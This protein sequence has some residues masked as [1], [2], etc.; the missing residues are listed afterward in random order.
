[1]YVHVCNS[2][3]RGF[4]TVQLDVVNFTPVAPQRRSVQGGA[5][6]LDAVFQFRL[7]V[8]NQPR[9]CECRRHLETAERESVHSHVHWLRS[10]TKQEQQKFVLAFWDFPSAWT[11][12]AVCREHSG[13]TVCESWANQSPASGHWVHCGRYL[14]CMRPFKAQLSACW[15]NKHRIT[16]PWSVC[17]CVWM[18]WFSTWLE[19]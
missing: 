2:S 10:T 14:H 5:A 19:L 9:L 3:A 4:L 17:E 6:N 8:Q 13:T 16:S 12:L 18:S 11:V 15:L 1:M 7:Q